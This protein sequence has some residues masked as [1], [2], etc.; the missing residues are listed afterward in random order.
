LLASL[1]LLTLPL[2]PVRP[3]LFR[4]WYSENVL[5]VS[6]LRVAL[7]DALLLPHCSRI[8]FEVISQLISMSVPGVS[9]HPKL[10]AAKEYYNKEG[11][12]QHVILFIDNDDNGSIHK[13]RATK[14]DDPFWDS[15]ERDVDWLTECRKV[16]RSTGENIGQN[17][18]KILFRAVSTLAARP[19]GRIPPRRGGGGGGGETTYYA[20]LPLSKEAPRQD[21]YIVAQSGNEGD[22][23]NVG[24]EGMV[25]V[26]AFGRAEPGLEM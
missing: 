16:A 10:L 1:S 7:F 4:R 22:S 12:Y 21:S 2:H 14:A 5:S 8:L 18:K 23:Y 25:I 11:Q 6:L 3:T 20:F 24:R 15:V 26:G 9:S 19:P 13:F 17:N